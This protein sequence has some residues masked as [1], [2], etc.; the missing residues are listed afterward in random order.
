MKALVFQRKPTRYFSAMAAGRVAPGSGAKVGPLRLR[1]DHDPPELPGP[2]WRYIKPRLSG[3]CGSDL[4]TLDGKSSRYFEPIVSFPFVPGHEVVADLVDTDDPKAEADGT[5]RVVLEPVLGCV[6]RGIEPVCRFCAQGDLG[7]CVNIAFGH[8]EPGLQSGFCCDTGGGWSTLMVAHESQ[9]HPVPDG[10]TDPA[11]VMVE[12]AACAV[13]AAGTG[14]SAGTRDGSVV[15]LGA[16]T[17]GLL[18]VASLTYFHP[19]LDVIAV[20]KHPEQRRLARI[21]GASSVVEPGELRRAVRRLRG[22]MA[23]GA[24]TIDCV[25]D[26]VGAVYDCVGTAE[27][28]GTA[29]S[30]LAPRGELFLVGMAGDVDLD[31]TPMWQKEISLRGVYAYGNEA[32][33]GDRR[34]FD[35]AFELVQ[36]KDL[37]RLVSTTY[38]LSRYTEAIAHAGNAGVRGA[39]KI[40]FDLTGEKERTR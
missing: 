8:L 1:T 24:G 9:L 40:A 3:I 31:L 18:T 14:G 25:T 34:S 2:G 30:V 21:L 29:I 11:A 17:L 16:G 20:A 15:V 22:S 6:T 5:N 13:H 37:A 12:P 28:I 35:L 27:S 10:M 23:L 36:A 38:P 32:H 19:D 26:G 39:V 7:N 4:S 33:L